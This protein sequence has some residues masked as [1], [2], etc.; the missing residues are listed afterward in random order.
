MGDW[1]IPGKGDII[2]LPVCGVTSE[3]DAKSTFPTLEFANIIDVFASGKS[4]CM[5]N[6]GLG[7]NKLFKFK[8]ML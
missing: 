5:I 1:G 4:E 2:M 7:K 8:I 6:S 3:P